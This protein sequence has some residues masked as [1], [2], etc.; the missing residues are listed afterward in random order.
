MNMNTYPHLIKPVLIGVAGVIGLGLVILLTIRLVTGQ[1]LGLRSWV[2]ASIQS[3][4]SLGLSLLN[5]GAVTTYSQGNFTNIVFLHHSVGNN[6]INQGNVRK[7]LT[8]NGYKFFDHDY[9]WSGL[10]GTDGAYLGYSYNIPND[11]TDPDGLVK[12]FSQFD[13]GA[14]LNTFSRLLQHEVIAFKSCFPASNIVS[15]EQLAERK[16][17][18]L[19]M[20]VAMDRRPDKLFIVMTQPPLNPAETSP[21]IAARARAFANWLKSEEYLG[22]HPNIVTFD[23][24]GYLAEDNPASSDYNMLRQ[25]YREGED[26][27]PNQIANET[28]GPLFA[29]FIMNVAQS[30]REVRHSTTDLVSR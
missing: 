14:P 5:S 15:D 6:L 24:F 11:N 1:S 7:I 21:E 3:T 27:H 16:T 13:F 8:Q 22:G 2:S 19:E 28:I 23:L 17:W 9:N 25:V 18:Y 4:K 20:R 30:Y 10:R 29:D 12:I 26:S